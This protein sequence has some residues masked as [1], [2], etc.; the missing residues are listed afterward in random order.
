[1]AAEFLQQ[2]TGDKQH[3]AHLIGQF[4]VGF[5]S[6]FIVADKVSVETRRA[7]L[8]T[9]AAVRWE[10]DGEGEFTGSTSTATTLVGGSNH[11]IDTGKGE[12]FQIGTSTGTGDFWDGWVD[13]IAVWKTPVQKDTVLNHYKVGKPRDKR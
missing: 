11:V 12:V 7:G 2:M 1:M 13:E 6:A 3:D 8:E 10:S 4:G 9:D 5:Y